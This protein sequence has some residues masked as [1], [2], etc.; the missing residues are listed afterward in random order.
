MI[1]QS[2]AVVNHIREK[3]PRYLDAFLRVVGILPGDGSKPLTEKQYAALYNDVDSFTAFLPFKD[4]NEDTQTF[5]FEDGAS[6]GAA[7]EL[8]PVD[9]EG[10]SQDILKNVEHGISQAFQNIPGHQDSPWI[11]QIYL[12]DDPITGLIEQLRDYATPEAKETKHHE[13]WMG[14]LE[15]H[16]RHMSSDKGLFHDKSSQFWWRGQLRKVRC[17]IY[18]R[19]KKEEWVTKSGK[20]IAGRGSPSMELNEVAEAFC[21][22]LEQTGIGVTRY[23]GKELYQWLLPWFSPKPD[24]FEDARDYLSIKK[25]PE[26]N[27][28]FG[29]GADL[30]E[31][32]TLGYPVSREDGSWLFTGVPHRLI[33]LQ[34]ISS[35]PK[36]GVLTAE[37]ETHSG[38]SASMW[39]RLP[40]DS[41][42][43]TTIVIQPQS[44][45]K[46][47]CDNIIKAA[48]QGSAEAKAASTQAHQAIDNIATGR[49]IYPTFS[50]VYVKGET[51]EEFARNTRSALHIL[52]AFGF[53]PVIP[54]Y[55]PTATDNYLRFLPMVYSFEHD[56]AS[57]GDAT[58]TRMTYVDH[59]SCILPLYGRGTGTGNPGKLFFNRIGEP[60]T[61][62][63][64]LDKA[65]VAHSLIFGPTGSGKSATI[66]YMVLH[67]MAMFFPR[68]FII[69]KG[70][71]FDLLAKYFI[72][73]G[74][75]VNRVTFKP[76]V[77][78]SLPPFIKAFE[79]L[80]QAEENEEAMV[81]A[82]NTSADDAFN[83]DGDMEEEDQEVRDYLGEMELIT[84]MMMTG[85]DKK[86]EEK[87]ELPDKLM[88]RRAL[89]DA[90]RKQRD[91][92]KDYMIPSNV[93]EVI[94][95]YAKDPELTT[96]KRDRYIELA[97]AL[98]YWTQG[99]HGLFFNRP[100]KAWPECDLTVLDMGILTSEQYQDMLAVALVSLLNT[101]TGIGEKNQFSGR[102]TDVYTDEGHVITTNPTLVKPLVF[103]AKTW[104]K[105]NIWLHQ[106]TQNLGDYPAEAKKMLSLAEWWLCLNM[107]K[108][109]VK[110]I[111]RFRP[112]TKEQEVLLCSA[113]KEKGKYTEGVVLSDRLT[114]LFR[115]VVPALPLALAGT[116]SDEKKARRKIMDEQGI[117]E[118]EAIDQVVD[119][120]KQARA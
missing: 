71:S 52:T 94:R 90:T 92:D 75:S 28:C 32:M 65:R 44:K 38:K 1:K 41:I 70:G 67:D 66:N 82:L 101:I 51:E 89:L 81:F 110:E 114:S 80:A 46:V 43:V 113:R 20:P 60:L 64:V 109:E 7:F 118:L 36:T 100:G 33:S 57:L 17:V 78:I 3:H 116:D 107:T 9:V 12:Q 53:N 55:D 22:Q 21:G 68:T 115:I 4:Y 24:G 95:D 112:V 42:F 87:I 45:I 50:G 85:A 117:T 8:K 11:V 54:R 83:K 47:H 18:R 49:S 119:K 10:C 103:A 35:A 37:Q 106:A 62:D 31:M 74:F 79:A 63:Q 88:I 13:H 97:D 99:L 108:D 6:V 2:Q 5:I 27:E 120:I 26:D 72:R 29:A 61:F 76:G 25:F 16:L 48:G 40:K 59:L 105:L 91:A 69:E 34:A 30:A 56:K 96:K 86:K 102:R 104:R 14:E 58:L 73:M 84:R 77:D 19:S 98:D 111:E 93:V 39:D 15:E 23:S